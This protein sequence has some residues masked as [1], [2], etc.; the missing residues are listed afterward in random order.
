MK[1]YKIAGLVIGFHFEHQGFFDDNIEKYETNQKPNYTIEVKTV[2]SIKAPNK[3]ATYIHKNRYIYKDGHKETLVVYNTNN[4][5][6]I[7][8]EHSKDYKT[9]RIL[10]HKD[11]IKDLA[12]TEYVLS[13]IQFMRLALLNNR[14]PLHAIAIAYK[15]EAILFAASSGIGKSTHAS[16][17]KNAIKG[18]SIINDDKPLIYKNNNRFIVCGSPWS[19]K[20]CINNN[21]CHP[22]K[23]IVFLDRGDTNKVQGI[24]RKEAIARF[25]KDCMRSGDELLMNNTLNLVE[26][27]LKQSNY[28]KYS[29]TKDINSVNS[30]YKE[31]YKEDFIDN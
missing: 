13:G 6:K 20:S 28:Y 16:N 4:D 21:V 19:G 26:D 25:M 31:L 9:Q 23:A 27:L 8:M 12:E 17:W 30:I 5:A 14:L 11:Y 18:I 24:N 10:L 1:A 29:L 22:L 3:K 2:N 7:M 15:N